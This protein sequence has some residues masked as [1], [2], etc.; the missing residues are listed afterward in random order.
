M[1]MVPYVQLSTI[2]G[3]DK[4]ITVQ[5]LFSLYQKPITQLVAKCTYGIMAFPCLGQSPHCFCVHLDN[6]DLNRFGQNRSQLFFTII[7]LE[8]CTKNTVLVTQS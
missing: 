1:A 6:V 4:F 3:L 8:L 7:K 2:C 5:I